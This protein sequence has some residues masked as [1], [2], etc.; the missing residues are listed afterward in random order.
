MENRLRETIPESNPDET[1]ND[2]LLNL[3]LAN[4]QLEDNDLVVKAEDTERS[5][6]NPQI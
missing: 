2:E 1:I 5:P 6:H 4:H 3:S